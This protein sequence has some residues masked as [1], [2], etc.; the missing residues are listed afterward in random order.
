MKFPKKYKNLDELREILE[1]QVDD[2][3][4]RIEALQ[5]DSNSFEEELILQYIEKR[6]TPIVAK[7]AKSKGKK[8]ARGTVY[9]PSDISKLI[10]E[11]NDNINP[12]LLRMAREIFEFNSKAVSRRYY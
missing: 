12:V 2:L 1:Y 11:G 5:I 8:T 6:S 7:F 9:T 4:E 3:E 10:K